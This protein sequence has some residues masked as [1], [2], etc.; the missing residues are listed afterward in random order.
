MKLIRLHI[1]AYGKLINYDYEFENVSTFCE[2]NGFGKSTI[3]S[4]IKAMFYGLESVKD[5]N[6][7]FLDRMHFY[8]FSG[9]NFGGNIEF[10]YNGHIFRIERTFDK[11]ALPKIL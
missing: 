1:N 10:S 6:V 8:P 7:Q 4:F 9:G 11:K 5:N 2:E 3:V